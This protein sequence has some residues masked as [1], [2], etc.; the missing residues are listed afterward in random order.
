ML[1]GSVAEFSVSLSFHPLAWIG[2]RSDL[3]VVRCG[4]WEA[5]GLE[6]GRNGVS[7]AVV[8]A[9]PVLIFPSPSHIKDSWVWFINKNQS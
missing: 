1:A 2:G 9:T 4:K 8:S 6:L 5:V 3:C 7:S